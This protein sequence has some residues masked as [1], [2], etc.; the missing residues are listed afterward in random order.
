LKNCKRLSRG[1]MPWVIALAVSL[2]AF[3]SEAK[4]TTIAI[5]PFSSA[6]GLIVLNNGVGNN[7]TFSSDTYSFSLT[8][9]ANVSGNFNFY[10]SD[11]HYWMDI[12]VASTAGNLVHTTALSDHIDWSIPAF[13]AGTP[14]LFS[15]DLTPGDYVLTLTGGFGPYTGALALA[16]ATAVTP[17]PAALP[18]FASALGGLGFVG[19]RRRK[20]G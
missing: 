3:M 20:R 14:G 2:A 8:D 4:A 5:G 1:I 11:P 16:A 17:I 7:L 13:V 6:S 15:L 18:L 12:D 10:T 9:T 19:W